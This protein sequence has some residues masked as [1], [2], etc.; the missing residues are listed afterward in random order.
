MAEAFTRENA[1]ADT[2]RVA[3]LQHGTSVEIGIY[4]A[5]TVVYV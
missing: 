1:K 5:V 2:H 3:N 4:G